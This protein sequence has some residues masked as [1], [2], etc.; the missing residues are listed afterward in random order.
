MKPAPG[1]IELFLLAQERETAPARLILMLWVVCRRL[2][3]EVEALEGCRYDREFEA[4][5]VYSITLAEAGVAGV[6]FV[7][8]RGQVHRLF[9]RAF[10]GNLCV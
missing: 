8:F 9:P 5:G 4:T 3:L 1:V 10:L 6:P 7:R 2:L